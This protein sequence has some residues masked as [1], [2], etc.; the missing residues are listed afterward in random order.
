MKPVVVLQSLSTN[1][2]Y[3]I[4]GMF[5]TEVTSL[6]AKPKQENCLLLIMRLI[7]L[8]SID[9][10]NLLVFCKIQPFFLFLLSRKNTKQSLVC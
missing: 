10:L 7:Q 3:F 5:G 8:F 2:K 4:Q 1:F 9:L 6:H